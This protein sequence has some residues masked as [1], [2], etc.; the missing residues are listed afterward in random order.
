MK[1]NH[2]RVFCV[3]VFGLLCAAA[4]VAADKKSD[5]KPF[6]QEKK[7][8]ASRS[9]FEL[10]IEIGNRAE[11]SYA[12]LIDSSTQQCVYSGPLMSGRPGMDSKIGDFIVVSKKA[13]DF[14]TKYSGPMLYCL[15]FGFPNGQ[16]TGD[17]FHQGDPNPSHGCY[18]NYW[19]Q[20]LVMFEA[21]P[22]GTPVHVAKSFN[23]KFPKNVNQINHSILRRQG[24]ED[25]SVRDVFAKL[26]PGEINDDGVL[27]WTT[28]SG[29]ATAT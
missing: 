12:F 29:S 24:R 18:R 23:G 17:C 20:A 22:V 28:S 4:S 27:A 11:E 7:P 21:V 6:K 15:R 5:L 9:K 26:K 2:I 19:W 10:Y 1:T 16:P 13:N 25:Q 8:A 3:L 14:S